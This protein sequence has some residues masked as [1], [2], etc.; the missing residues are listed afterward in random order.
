VKSA[1]IEENDDGSP[2]LA[3]IAEPSER[4][5]ILVKLKA[6]K[7]AIAHNH[8]PDASHPASGSGE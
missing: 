3:E 8:M 1:E 2:K 7:L 4:H 6:W 5:E